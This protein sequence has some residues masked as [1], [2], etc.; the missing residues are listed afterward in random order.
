ML[1][2][3][4]ALKNIYNVTNDCSSSKNQRDRRIHISKVNRILPHL[5]EWI[6]NGLQS[7]VG[8]C[9]GQ[10]LSPKVQTVNILPVVYQVYPLL[11]KVDFF[12]V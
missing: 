9:L 6:H 4:S 10:E 5:G 1:Q 7:W 2:W 12:I 11:L 8:V 3:K